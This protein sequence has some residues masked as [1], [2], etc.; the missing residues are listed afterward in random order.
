VFQQQ[1]ELA[2]FLMRIEAL[3]LSLKER[4]TLFFDTRTPPFDLFS[5]AIT[6]KLNK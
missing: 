3:E 4:S 2:N 6:N 1:P 5:G